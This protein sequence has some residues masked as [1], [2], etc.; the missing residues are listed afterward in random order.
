MAPELFSSTPSYGKEVD[1]WA[2][3]SMIYE[4]ATG[5][6]PNAAIGVPYE[7]LGAHL[8]NHVTRLE[9]GNYSSDLRDLVAYSLQEQP[10]A[11]PTRIKPK[12]AAVLVKVKVF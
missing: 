10:S 11:R 6:P 8:K 12:S 7:K 4:I 3:G 5:Y 2:F 9:G 1:I